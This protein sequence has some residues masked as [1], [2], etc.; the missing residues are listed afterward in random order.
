MK[1][2]CLLIVTLLIASQSFGQ[3][4]AIQSSRSN[5]IEGKINLQQA[6]DVALQNN[7]Q[8]KQNNLSADIGVNNLNQARFNRLPQVNGSFSQS[9]SFGRT[10]DPFTNGYIEQQ[11][12]FQNFGIN[13]G[14]QI[15]GGYQLQ[16]AIKQSEQN[17]QAARMDVQTT[18]DNI[19]LNVVLAYLSILN[20][21]DLLAIAK[22]QIGL[23][24]LQVERT[25][26]LVNAGA[27]P[28]TNL[29][30]L[31]AQLANDEGAIVNAENTLDLSKLNLLQLMNVNTM[32][33]I[34]LSRITLALPGTDK[35]DVTSQGV[36]DIAVGFQPVIK[37]AEYRVQSAATGIEIA[38]AIAMPRLTFGGSLGSNYSS[39]APNQRFITDVTKTGP[40]VPSSSSYV[41]VNGTKQPIITTLPG[42]SYKDFGYFSQ[43]NFNR[44]QGL[45][46]SLSV[47]I[48]NNYRAKT[49]VSNAIIQKK[50]QE[51]AVENTKLQLRQ[52]IETAYN[53]MT[54]ASKRYAVSQR[55]VEA[56]ELAFKASESRF[57]VGALNSVDYN[58]AKT[59]LDRAK[60]NLVQNK[61]DY[62]FRTKI[63]DYYQNKPLSF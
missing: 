52:S 40:D 50:I 34:E 35:Y 21:E 12:G 10:I 15:F 3:S 55:Q 29:L 31:K 48:F 24:R 5:S 42:G 36:F 13:A 20:N 54:A 6:I 9:V 46:L 16:N 26:K 61:Y 47:P 45:Q 1:Q 41:L 59:N 25:E 53:N 60:V 51:Y 32:Q 38:K 17:L 11:V 19:A 23:T 43:L 30:D 58:L 14:V 27:L 8:V 4:S 62:I 63:L 33:D 18:K 49:Q 57:N 56:L 44:N 37:A 2:Y 22:S 7:I 39:A 28:Q